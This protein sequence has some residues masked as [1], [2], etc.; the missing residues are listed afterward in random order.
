MGT[1][2]AFVLVTTS[3]VQFHVCIR[4]DISLHNAIAGKG[5]LYINA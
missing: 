2:F 4:F 3:K 1:V 5:M